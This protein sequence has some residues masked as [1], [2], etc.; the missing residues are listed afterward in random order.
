MVVMVLLLNLIAIWMYF[1]FST[2]QVVAALSAIFGDDRQLYE[3]IDT[4][5]SHLKNFKGVS[6]RFE[7]IGAIHGY[8]IFDDYAH[9]PTEV[10]A[11]LQAARKLFPL[12]EL[13]VVF[14]P[15]TYRYLFHDAFVLPILLLGL[16]SNRIEPNRKKLELCSFEFFIESTSI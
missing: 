13:L 12:K 2:L 15:H 5:R 1:T 16:Y 11:V 14:Q 8:H 4:V 9:H 7:L 6:R 10:R 3:S